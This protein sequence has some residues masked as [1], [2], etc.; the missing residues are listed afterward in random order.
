VLW[1][2]FLHQ[3]VGVAPDP[4]HDAAEWIEHHLDDANVRELD[5]L[6]AS[7]ESNPQNS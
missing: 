5:E 1:E 4:V 7:A 3:Q 6:L 2:Q